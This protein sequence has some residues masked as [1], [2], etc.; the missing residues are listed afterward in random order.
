LGICS[1]NCQADVVKVDT[2]IH[3]LSAKVQFVL[4]IDIQE[5]KFTGH[6]TKPVISY[7]QESWIIRRTNVR[8]LI[9]VEEHVMRR[10]AGYTLSGYARNYE[11]IREL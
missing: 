5:Y 10:T 6:F 4:L 7:V 9:T 1:K 2:G 11:I 3:K 8:K